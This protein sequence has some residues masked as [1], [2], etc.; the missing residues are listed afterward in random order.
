MDY[1]YLDSLSQRFY[2]HWA[3]WYPLQTTGA[4]CPATHNILVLWTFVFNPFSYIYLRI[5]FLRSWICSDLFFVLHMTLIFLLSC[6]GKPLL[7]LKSWLSTYHPSL[8]PTPIPQ[9]V[10]V[11]FGGKPFSCS[12]LNAEQWLWCLFVGFGELVW[13]QV[14][15]SFSFMPVY[16][17]PYFSI[18]TGVSFQV[19]FSDLC[20]KNMKQER[21]KTSP[22]RFCCT[23]YRI[24]YLSL[25]SHTYLSHLPSSFFFK[26]KF[27]ISNLSIDKMLQTCKTV[28]ALFH[29]LPYRFT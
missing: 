2:L 23:I 16:A 12:P 29:P 17:L 9:I 1:L 28:A 26:W 22:N 19:L 10:I 24:V 21:R 15:K 25:S 13:G 27:Y 8:P 6:S 3:L 18:Y 7:V 11:Q 20:P 4:S 14:R 5:W